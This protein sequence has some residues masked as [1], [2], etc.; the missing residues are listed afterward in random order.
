MRL[1]LNIFMIYG[2]AFVIGMF[3]A[4]IIWLLYN[5]MNSEHLKRL[6]HREAYR[7][8]KRLKQKEQ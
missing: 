5:T 4:G 7:D 8:M 3:V 1:I 6:T 2:L